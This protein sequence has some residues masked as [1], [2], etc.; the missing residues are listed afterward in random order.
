MNKKAI[1]LLKMISGLTLVDDS[2]N[3][4][5]DDANGTDGA[6]NRRIPCAK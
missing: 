5:G 1:R 2:L 4:F 6:S 3:T